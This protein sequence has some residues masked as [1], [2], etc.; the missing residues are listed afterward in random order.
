MF[1]LT[2]RLTEEKTLLTAWILLKILASAS[3]SAVL[4]LVLPDRSKYSPS[5]LSAM[6]RSNAV[7]PGPWPPV[8]RT[9]SMV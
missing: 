9:A 1:T 2:G 7:Q 6:L 5:D 3:M 4:R 8:A